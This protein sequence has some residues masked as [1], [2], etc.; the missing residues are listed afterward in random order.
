M[1]WA[2]HREPLWFARPILV[3]PL[4]IGLSACVGKIGSSGNGGSNGTT[5]PTGTAGVPAGSAGAGAGSV[6]TGSGGAG[7]TGSVQVD[8]GLPGRALIRRLSNAEYDATIKTLLGDATGYSSAFPGDSAING[9][10]NNTDVQDVGPA[11]AEQYTIVAEQ[12]SAKATQN[13]DT[14]LGCKL[15][16]GET[17]IN[18]FITRFGKRAWRRPLDSAEQADLLTVF[19]AGRD[20]F[21]ATAG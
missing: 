10:T 21:D 11:L 13:T 19:R 3:L 15:A 7:G 6:A 1:S 18:D 9:F 16:T 2:R 8:N 17:C 12:I 14:L 4:A 5:T 20:G